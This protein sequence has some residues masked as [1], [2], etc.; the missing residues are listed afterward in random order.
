MTINEINNL[1]ILDIVQKRHKDGY[2]DVGMITGRVIG[3]SLNVEVMFET[4][5]KGVEF[6]W[7]SIVS[8]YAF[9]KV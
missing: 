4:A 6:R 5:D 7:Y 9:D 3:N 2:V 1:K 8:L